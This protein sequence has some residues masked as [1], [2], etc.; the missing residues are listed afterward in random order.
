MHNFESTTQLA[1]VNT[2]LIRYFIS[3]H[4]SCKGICRTLQIISIRTLHYNIGT[5]LLIIQSLVLYMKQPML[6]H[7]IWL[8]F[9]LAKAARD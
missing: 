5:C 6:F 8:P 1:L 4:I 7:C 9:N 2:S 3:K